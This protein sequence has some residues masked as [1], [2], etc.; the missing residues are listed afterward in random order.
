MTVVRLDD[1][2]VAW[3]DADSR[4]VS[5]RRRWARRRRVQHWARCDSEALGGE[6]SVLAGVVP[7]GKAAG[8]TVQFRAVGGRVHAS[9]LMACGL[10]W[11]CP[12][13]SATIRIRRGLE[14]AAAASQHVARGGRLAM[15][16][17]TVRHSAAMSLSEVLGAVA[18]SWRMMSNRSAWRS[19]RA[20]CV[21]Y[22]RALEITVGEN[23]WHP[24]EHILLFLRAGVDEVQAS[25]FNSAMFASWSEAATN[26][27]TV[28]PTVDRGFDF[29]WFG[30]SAEAAAM[31]V[32]KAARELTFAD[33]KSGRDPFSLLDSGDDD[34]A[35]LF[36]EYAA[37]TYR[38]KAISWSRGLRS[39]F[40]LAPDKSD[41]EVV[42]ESQRVGVV[43]AEMASA[44]WNSLSVSE[45]VDW[46][47][48]WELTLALPWASTA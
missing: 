12:S 27:L 22:V 1:E 47:E 40:D 13:C 42:D 28:S 2:G 7:C 44:L 10:I 48:F 18:D 31:Y 32:T 35:S 39:H 36:L 41:R 23:G 46:L 14:L 30:E 6:R 45:R 29:V 26:A 8:A 33:S 17:L 4:G 24:H 19:L 43:V 3:L 5:R 9:G 25:A 38:R 34:A 16:T 15:I 20:N 37:A 11:L 21:G